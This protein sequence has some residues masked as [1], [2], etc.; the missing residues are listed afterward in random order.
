M[1][2]FIMCISVLAMSNMASAQVH[3]SSKDVKKCWI[4]KTRTEAEN[5]VG[6]VLATATLI[7]KFCAVGDKIVTAQHKETYA[8][9]ETINHS[10]NEEFEISRK[11]EL[12]LNNTAR[13]VDQ[14][15]ITRSFAPTVILKWASVNLPFAGDINL[16]M[17]LEGFYSGHVKGSAECSVY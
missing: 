4:G 14:K 11:K 7:G 12:I 10:V 8:E 9:T 13:I 6:G 16:C 3:E 15:Q 17:K 5:R 2:I 1:A